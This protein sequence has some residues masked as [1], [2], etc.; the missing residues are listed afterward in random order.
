LK[1]SGEERRL[2]LRKKME[3]A[4]ALLRGKKG[5]KEANGEKARPDWEAR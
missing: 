5:G 3:K 2:Y 4:C 1:R